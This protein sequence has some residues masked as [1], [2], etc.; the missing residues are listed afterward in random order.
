MRRLFGAVAPM[1]S[2]CHSR[3]DVVAA[4]L[5]SD[6][7]PARRIAPDA[8]DPAAAAQHLL[9]YVLKAR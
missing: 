7:A 4:A 9:A 1:S 6:Q 2:D 3:G 8:H 5:Q